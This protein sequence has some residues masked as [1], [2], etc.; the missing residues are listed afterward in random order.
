[1]IYQF[2]Q[3][4]LPLGNHKSILYF[5]SKTNTMIKYE[6]VDMKVELE[7]AVLNYTQLANKYNISRPTVRAYAKRLGLHKGN[8]VRLKTHTLNEDYFK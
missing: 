1:M 5:Y 3:F 7:K 6:N 8:T 4:T 2:N